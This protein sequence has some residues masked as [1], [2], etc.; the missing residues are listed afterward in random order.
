MVNLQKGLIGHWTMNLRE[1]DGNIVRDRSAIGVHGEVEGDI[2]F[3]QGKIGEALNF[4]DDSSMVKVGDPTEF[5]DFNQITVSAWVRQDE[6]SDIS[7]FQRIIDKGHYNTCWVDDDNSRVS[8]RLGADKDTQGAQVSFSTD[9]N[10]GEWYH[11]VFT[12][13]A[14]RTET[15][16]LFINGEKFGTNDEYYGVIS[17]NSRDLVIGN[18]LAEDRP[19]VGALEDIRFYNRTLS[20]REIKALYNLRS[21][22][23]SSRSLGRGLVGHWSLDNA[24]TDSMVVRDKTA[25][26]NDAVINDN[27]GGLV[28]GLDSPVCGSFEFDSS[29]N[30]SGTNLADSD[31]TWLAVPDREVHRP[32]DALSVA[33]WIYSNGEQSN[34][35]GSM[36]WKGEASVEDGYAVEPQSN[37]VRVNYGDEWGALI[38]GL[39]HNE[40]SHWVFIYDNGEASLYR[41]GQKVDSRSDLALPQEED[42]LWIGRRKGHYSHVFDGKISDVRIYNRALS[43]KEVKMLFNRRDKR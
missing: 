2:D 14:D 35:G 7:R 5:A 23:E 37:I 39:P 11:I 6:V 19:W 29:N 42:E 20:E 33:G 13:D 15:L 27:T 10:K 3:E 26:N 34:N 31:A 40:W 9:L 4:E 38:G 17:S 12:Y 28:K 32:S 41:N 1:V 22:S 24:D 18:W 16:H 8:I 25:R 43:G 21:R 36:V 30:E